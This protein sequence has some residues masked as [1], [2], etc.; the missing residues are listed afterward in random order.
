MRKMIN[1]ICVK[2]AVSKKKDTILKKWGCMI[3]WG[4]DMS[5]IAY[6]GTQES[7]TTTYLFTTTFNILSSDVKHSGR[8][9]EADP[10]VVW[11]SKIVLPLEE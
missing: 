4:N 2:N 1:S 3:S 8:A 5:A 10:C 11:S 7:F 9:V 6:L